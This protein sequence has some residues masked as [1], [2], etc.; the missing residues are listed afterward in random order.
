[1][2]KATRATGSNASSKLQT[3]QSAGDASSANGKGKGLS[4]LQQ[5]TGQVPRQRGFEFRND[6][7]IEKYSDDEVLKLFDANLAYLDNKDLWD[8]LPQA[9]SIQII[10]E[11]EVLHQATMFRARRTN[12]STVREL[13]MAAQLKWL[14]WRVQPANGPILLNAE[15]ER[16]GR[17]AKAKEIEASHKNAERKGDRSSE[18]KKS[19]VVEPEQE[20]APVSEET[21]T[22]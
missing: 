14:T 16:E 13:M 8:L 3:V 1:M 22:V 20:P 4:A 2:A 15:Q 10:T 17:K 19:Q 7:V 9:Q 5:F 18:K 6:T 21:Q 12:D 11:L